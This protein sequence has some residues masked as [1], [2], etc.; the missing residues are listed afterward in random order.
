MIFAD[1]QGQTIIRSLALHDDM[2]AGFHGVALA[3]IDEIELLRL[4]IDSLDIDFRMRLW[5]I[6]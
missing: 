1:F 4:R 5:N 3:T 6:G 2:P